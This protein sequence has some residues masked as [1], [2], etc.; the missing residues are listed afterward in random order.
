MK[1]M[2]AFLMMVLAAGAR[3]EEKS[4][5]DSVVVDVGLSIQARSEFASA[6][7][8]IEFNYELQ[9]FLNY[10]FD[11]YWSDSYRGSRIM[12]NELLPTAEN[13]NLWTGRI[14]GTEWMPSSSLMD[15]TRVIV[16]SYRVIFTAYAANGS[17]YVS[18]SILTTTNQQDELKL[19]LGAKSAN[20]RLSYLYKK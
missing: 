7:A 20:G 9:D 11:G 3:A 6:N 14:S 18:H 16:K 19:E 2:F 8:C 4:V 15:R 17:K 13:P 10:G 1:E 12:C 5:L